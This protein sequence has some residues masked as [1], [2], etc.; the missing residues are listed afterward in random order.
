MAGARPGLHDAPLAHQ[1]LTAMGPALPS[2][3][4]G[5]VTSDPSVPTVRS[6]RQILTLVL[7]VAW[8]GSARADSTPFRRFAAEVTV[9]PG[10]GGGDKFEA[11]LAFALGAGSDGIDARRESVSLRIGP[12]AFTIPPGSFQGMAPGPFA[13]QGSV[14]GVALTATIV[15]D[16]GFVLT[17]DGRSAFLDA[18]G[19]LTVVLRIA[20]DLGTV[21]VGGHALVSAAAPPRRVDAALAGEVAKALMPEGRVQGHPDA[22]DVRGRG[23]G[24]AGRADADRDQG[25]EDGATSGL[26]VRVPSPTGNPPKSTGGKSLARREGRWRPESARVVAPARPGWTD[27]SPQ[28]NRPRR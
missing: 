5:I 4:P 11:R 10:D 6:M 25:G 15:P 13:Y 27:R 2:V 14:D 19:P 22:E 8:A 24:V 18:S 9:R 23:Q 17:V 28:E 21:S 3:R 12:L 20:N 26:S 1:A 7:G 16:D